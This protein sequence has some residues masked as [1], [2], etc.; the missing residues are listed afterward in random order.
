MLFCP[1]G[2][3][4]S[5][6]VWLLLGYVGLHHDAITCL[7][8]VH[9]TV[10]TSRPSSVR[11]LPSGIVTRRFSSKSNSSATP[12]E[13][14][15]TLNDPPDAFSSSIT[16]STPMGGWWKRLAELQAFRFRHGHC[17]V[18]KRY[19]E[20]PSLG[21]FVNKQRQL[22]R[23]YQQG[24][25]TSL[26]AE[27]IAMLDAMGFCWD[28]SVST[29]QLADNDDDDDEKNQQHG[30]SAND[31]SK[32]HAD[33]TPSTTLA[34]SATSSLAISTDREIGRSGVLYSTKS[35]S[36]QH[37]EEKW[38]KRLEEF[39]NYIHSNN[40]TDL[41]TIPSASTWGMWLNAQRTEYWKR[42]PS[43][44]SDP[45]KTAPHQHDA[46]KYLSSSSSSRLT[47]DMIQALESLHMDWNHRRQQI[48]DL[49]LRQLIEYKQEHGDTCVPITYAA[50]PALAQWISRQRKN[51][52]AKRRGHATTLTQE[53]M[54]QLDAIGFVWNR[55][56]YE[57]SKKTQRTRKEGG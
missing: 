21:N 25:P 43:R 24:R 52:N 46:E 10:F 48:W 9:R 18:P 28:A 15:E 14:A 54:E 34:H 56:D 7:G 31:R 53:R 5:I 30:G 17:Q 2:G 29:K 57:F 38:W 49:R 36:Q 50:N 40:V 44:Q 32:H 55:W 26:T 4:S 51:Y 12:P 13:S 33:D 23:Q 20:N 41:T 27:R 3:S 1:L 42:P 47:N 39:K 37:Y 19:A 8:L 6:L 16:T 22:Y 35:V 11:L 45:E